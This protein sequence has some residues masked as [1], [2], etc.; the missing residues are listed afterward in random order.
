MKERCYI[1][2]NFGLLIKKARGLLFILKRISYILRV[3]KERRFYREE[4]TL[5]DIMSRYVDVFGC[6]DRF[7]VAVFAEYLY[8]QYLIFN[9]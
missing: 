8:N 9:E 5:S 6:G 4:D 7:L 3:S 1:Y 2:I